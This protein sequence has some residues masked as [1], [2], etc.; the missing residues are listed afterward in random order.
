MTKCECIFKDNFIKMKL[1][2][3]TQQQG[4]YFEIQALHY[5][6]S[7]GL[8]LITKNWHYKNMGEL[9]LVMLDK[10]VKPH[11]LVFI[12][13]RQRKITNFP[14]N[15]G[16]AEDSITP[17]KQKKIIKTAHAFLTYFNDFNTLKFEIQG[18]KH[19]HDF[20]TRFDVV[21]FTTSKKARQIE[22]IPQWIKGAFW[23][24]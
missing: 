14:N 17:A 2:S 23:V 22:W 3:P 7:Q 19:F 21:T 18:I 4:D 9:D 8:T 16:T 11:C 1:T 24:E 13:V 6:Q 20:D 15:F 5:L 12:E 10:T